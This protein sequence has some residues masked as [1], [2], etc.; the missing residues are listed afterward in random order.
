MGEVIALSTHAIPDPVDFVGEWFLPDREKSP[1]ISGTLSWAS[2]R[3]SLKLNDSFTPLVGAVY[4]DE[5]HSYAAVHGTSTNSQYVTLLNA[6]RAGSGFNFGAAGMRQSERL[7]SSLVVVGDHVSPKTLYSEIR[8]RLPG[9]QI[10]IGR[11]GVRQTIIP[12]TDDSAFTVIYSIE[13]LPEE[14]TAISSV[15][16]TLGWGL[17]WTGSGDLVSDISVKTSAYLSV[18]ADHPQDLDWYFK[19][20]GKVT[21]LLSFLASA[22]MS[23]DHITAKVFESAVEVE[24]LIA[25]RE[26]L[27]CPHKSAHDFYMLRNDMGADLGTVFSKWFELYDSIAMPSQL[28]LSVFSSEKLWLHVEFLS[29]MQALEGFHRATMPGL[30]TSVEE[31]DSIRGELSNAIPKGVESA[32]REALKSRI[33][34]GNEVSLRK[35]LDALVARVPLAIREQILGGDG[36]VPRS[37]VVTRNYYTHWDEASRDSILDGVEMHRAGVRMKHLLRVLYLDLVGIPFAAIAKALR[38]SCSES[39]YLVQLNNSAYRKK[40]P[41]DDSGAIMHISMKDAESPD[42]STS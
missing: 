39:Q 9:L 26:A 6:A 13:S 29:L 25:L 38:N 28:A 20:L 31:Y 17:G 2:Q 18:R 24:I 37:W 36:S 30:Y 41:G 32:H 7:I 1:L 19:Q 5:D 42:A 35:R 40:N 14:V 23:P 33:K 4:G 8:V 34:Y 27:Y 3:A 21:T 16:A 15:S 10:W 22:P 12:K 11:S